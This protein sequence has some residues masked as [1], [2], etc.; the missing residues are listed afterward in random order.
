[1]SFAGGEVITVA[2]SSAGILGAAWHDDEIIFGSFRAGLFR[3]SADGGEPEAL[4]TL[5]E[6]ELG[7]GWPTIIPGRAALVFVTTT[8]GVQDAELAVLDLVTGEITRLGLAGLDPHYVSTGHL[9]YAGVDGAVRAVPFDTAALDVTGVPVLLVEGVGIGGGA[10][11]D[12]SVSDTGR[13]VYALDTSRR[14]ERSLVW[15]ER[16]GREELLAAPSRRY[17]VPRI[18]PDGTR[19]LLGDG[20]NDISVWNI[21]DETL[22]TRSRVAAKGD[23][24]GWSP[25]ISRLAVCPDQ[26]AR[27]RP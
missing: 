6:G 12:F 3:V 18:S 22:T 4:T 19:I 27:E 8:S 17:G 21:A 2:E 11:A 23:A 1:M 10:G 15:V 7:H 20:E 25:A 26:A 16:D 13:L 14:V 5:D 9:V 24:R